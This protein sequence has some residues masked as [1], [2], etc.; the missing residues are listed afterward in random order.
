M[1][2]TVALKSPRGGEFP[3]GRPDLGRFMET[4]VMPWAG[5]TRGPLKGGRDRFT[6]DACRGAHPLDVEW[7]MPAVA[8]LPKPDFR[9]RGREIYSNAMEAQMRNA[10]YD[11][12]AESENQANA[13]HPREVV[14]P[15]MA[16]SVAMT[17]IR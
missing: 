17:A 6:C 4:V 9:H 14:L 3:P 1:V 8:T 11:Y 2:R 12:V 15:G 16:R 13:A 10:M 7:R 5:E